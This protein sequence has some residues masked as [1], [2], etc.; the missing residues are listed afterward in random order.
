MRHHHS[1]GK[2]RRSVSSLMNGNEWDTRPREREETIVKVI[3]S[4]VHLREICEWKCE[5]EKLTIDT[6]ESD[7]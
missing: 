3:V 7:D 5:Q 6:R 1:K 2:E 4:V